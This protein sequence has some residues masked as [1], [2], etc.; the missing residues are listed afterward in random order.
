MRWGR[1]QSQAV[2]PGPALEL[3]V[4]LELVSLNLSAHVQKKTSDCWI[5]ADS[6]SV[7]GA[8]K[9]RRMKSFFGTKV[10][11]AVIWPCSGFTISTISCSV[12]WWKNRNHVLKFTQS[13]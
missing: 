2:F 8:I 13:G 6:H 1:E 9:N 4:K 3:F 5:N 7:Q 10:V 12:F 11:H